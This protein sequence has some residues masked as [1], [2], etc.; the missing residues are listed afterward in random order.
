MAK[1]CTDSFGDKTTLYQIEKDLK[2]H[3]IIIR[4]MMNYINPTLLIKMVFHNK[5]VMKVGRW[6]T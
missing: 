2:A 5:N 4:F 1:I 6:T 3:S